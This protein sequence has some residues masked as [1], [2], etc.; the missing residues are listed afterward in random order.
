MSPEAIENELTKAKLVGQLYVYGNSLESTLL[1]VV[2]PD[3][4]NSKAWAAANASGQ[5]ELADIAALPA[6]K[7]ELL[8]QLGEKGKESK[9]KRYEYIKDVYIE[10][11]D[12][13]ALGQGFHVDNNLATPTFKLKRPQL[14]AKYKEILDGMYSRMK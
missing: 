9:L 3:I 12:L 7:Q 10:T 13:N 6:F 8:K 11:G 14:Q 5:T 2:V 1:G 4:P